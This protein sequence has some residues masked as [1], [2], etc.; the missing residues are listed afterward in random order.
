VE[1][2]GLK[3][4]LV[5][6]Y[7]RVILSY[8]TT[9]IAILIATADATLAYLSEAPL[10]DW[11]HTVVGIAVAILALLKEKKPAKA[12]PPLAPVAVLLLGC[13]FLLGSCAHVRHATADLLDCAAVEVTKALVEHAKQALGLEEGAWQTALQEVVAKG[14]PCVVYVAKQELEHAF[15][16]SMFRPSGQGGATAMVDEEPPRYALKIGRAEVWLEDHGVA[17]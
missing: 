15:E 14:G 6:I 17:R 2:T 1:N 3:G 8:K 9:L 10:P 13:T 7:Q 12:V 5:T 16:Q 4:L 11:V